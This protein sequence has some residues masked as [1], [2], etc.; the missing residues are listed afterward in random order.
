MQH[1][2]VVRTENGDSE[3]REIGRR[4]MQGSFLSPLLFSIYAKMMMIQAM[5]DVE[6]GVRVEAELLKDVKFSDDQGIVAQA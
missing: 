5:E 2:A 4:V 3:P 1:T 6:E